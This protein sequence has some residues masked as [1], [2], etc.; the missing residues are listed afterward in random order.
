MY[1][2]L[3]VDMNVNS[4]QMEKKRN[5][6]FLIF[7]F[8]FYILYFYHER[9]FMFCVYISLYII[10]S[11]INSET[12]MKDTIQVH[13][14]KCRIQC[15][16]PKVQLFYDPNLCFKNVESKVTEEGRRWVCKLRC[17]VC[18]QPPAASSSSTNVLVTSQISANITQ[19]YNSY[20]NK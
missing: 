16:W 19:D 13:Y 3:Q 8:L 12:L 9:L 5:N 17:L 20:H 18:F 10:S 15:F 2:N 11:F 4:H 7:S 6:V 1:L 14:G